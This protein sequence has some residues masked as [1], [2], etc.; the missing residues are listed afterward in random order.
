MTAAPV[1][2]G[3]KALPPP[4]SGPLTAAAAVAHSSG[5]Q[6]APNGRNP[7]PA[8]LGDVEKADTCGQR[9]RVCFPAPCLAIL[10]TSVGK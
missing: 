6:P 7:G 2:L 5:P 10:R 8:C 4:V 3:R 1:W 9:A